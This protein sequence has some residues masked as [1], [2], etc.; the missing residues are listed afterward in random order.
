[1]LHRGALRKASLRLTSYKQRQSR[2][3]DC[4]C[5]T[6]REQGWKILRAG[7]LAVMRFYSS[8]SQGGFTLHLCIVSAP[9]C[10]KQYRSDPA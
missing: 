10:K 2:L 6:G 3:G 5:F 4:R 7:F 8:V 9:A 1:A